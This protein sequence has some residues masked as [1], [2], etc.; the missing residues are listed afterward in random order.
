MKKLMAFLLVVLLS[1]PAVYADKGAAQET[2]KVLFA[3]KS[4]IQIPS[5]LTEFES[6][7]QNYNNRNTYNFMWYDKAYE[8]SVS[9]IADTEGRILNYNNYTS[10]FSKKK[11]TDISKT[12]IISFADSFL[13]KSLPEMYKD[14]SD[15]LILNEKSYR[16]GSGVLRYSFTYDRHKNSFPVKDNR[17]SVSVFVNEEGSL[18]IRNMDAYIDYG[19]V[20]TASEGEIPDLTQRYKEAFPVELIYINEYNPDRKTKGEQRQIPVLIYRN[21]DGICGYIDV[22]SGEIT[23]EDKSENGVFREE[24]AADSS[25]GSMNKN[26]AFT[27]KE[28][29]EL[30]AVEG[31]L[32]IEEITAKVKKLPFISFPAGL[33]LESSH[34]SKNDSGEYI[35]S[36]HYTNGNDEDYQYVII[37]A[38]AKDGKLKNYYV[39]GNI[40]F[41]KDVEIPEK[42]KKSLIKKADEFL[43]VASKEEFKSIALESDKETSGY[44]NLRYCR[45][46]NDVKH[47]S[48]GISLTFDAVSGNITSF[49]LNFTPGEFPRAEDVVGAEKAYENLLEYSPVIKTYIKNNGK[50]LLCAGLE[51][52]YVTIDAKTGNVKNKAEGEDISF[53]YEDIKGHWAEEA[54]TKLGEIQIGFR[55]E[56]LK[57]DSGVTQ[58]DFLRFIASGIRGKYYG[59]MDTDE[60]YYS[61]IREEIIREE[62]K[63]P[64]AFVKREDAF[65]YIVRMMNYEKI[66]KL[67]NIYK[68]N[69]SDGNLLSNGKIGYCA[70]LSGM[71]IVAGNGGYLRPG[72]NLTR[73]EAVVMLYRYMLEN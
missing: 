17:V 54:A 49:S 30:S 73:A 14:S 34:L 70:I 32:S 57:P 58:E 47:I 46:V 16:A 56:K 3:V 18:E 1:V 53:S 22:K 7:I 21:K 64:S 29:E 52:S 55:G 33:K 26:G 37:T 13:K 28:R 40:D 25:L 27:E 11:L 20:F 31:L 38:N 42:N 5:E 9:V 48:D 67:E 51:K 8:K 39:G 60:L 72:N 36:L 41:R 45:I 43:S 19:A 50:Y 59:N 66:A 65:V 61:L 6:E 35:Q 69:F 10:Q 62:E 15:V 2:E 12:E 4:K 23:E 44:L 24:A 71:G 68:V 63:A